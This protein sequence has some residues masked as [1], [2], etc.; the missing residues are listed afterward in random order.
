MF[1]SEKLERAKGFEPSTPTLARSFAALLQATPEFAIVSFF[2]IYHMFV[3]RG[4]AIGYDAF[5][6]G[7]LYFGD[8]LETKGRL[9]G[10]CLQKDLENA[11]RKNYQANH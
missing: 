10:F 3:E 8:I 9:R 6:H 2:S 4:S 1:Q 5:R 7:A 11:D